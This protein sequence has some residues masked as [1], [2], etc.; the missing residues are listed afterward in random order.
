MRKKKRIDPLPNE[1]ASYEE[2]AAFWD[3]HDTTDYPGA[4][5]TVKVVS[6]FRNRHYEIPIEPDV[7]SA[8]RAQARKR[9]ITLS[10]LAS[11]LLRRH[12]RA[13]G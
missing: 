8:L 1:F 9:G 10:R 7:V 2:A 3:A 4:F 13:V 5:R 6:Q 11:E 12:L